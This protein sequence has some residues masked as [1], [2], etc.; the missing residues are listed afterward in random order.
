MLVGEEPGRVPVTGIAHAT[1]RQGYDEYSGAVHQHHIAGLK[2][3]DA[4][5]FSSRVDCAGK[6]GGAGRQ[7]GYAPLPA[8]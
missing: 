1:G 6:D 7:T 3:A 8:G 5:S 4:Q 2:H